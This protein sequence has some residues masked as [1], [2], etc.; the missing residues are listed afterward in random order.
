MNIQVKIKTVYGV[1]HIYPICEKAKTFAAM[2]GQKTLTTNDV[3]H[4]K[5]LG[6]TVEVVS[7]Q[8]KTL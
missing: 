3:E 2:V 1:Q 8:P 7:D 5:K 6:F 4:I